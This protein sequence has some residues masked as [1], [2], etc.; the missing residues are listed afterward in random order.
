MGKGGGAPSEQRVT[1]TNIPDYAQPYVEETL[2]RA[3]ALT[4]Q[5]PYES[6]GGQRVAGFTPMEAQA[7]QNIAG[8]QFA[9][10][11]TEASNI[12]S[13]IGQQ[14]LGT[15]GIANLLQQQALGYGQAGAGYGAAASTLGMTGAQQAAMN[16]Q[17]AQ[18][19]AQMYGGQAAGFGAQ[20]AS[21]AAQAQ[22]ILSP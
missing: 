6:Y 7:F 3:Q 1:S 13:Q 15:Q 21:Q 16:A 19:Q 5:K 14:G 10:Q 12:A 4:T 8:Q 18:R 11:V 17:R 20:G 2:G 22:R 9:P